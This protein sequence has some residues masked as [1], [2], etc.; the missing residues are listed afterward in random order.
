MF[1]LPPNA[2]PYPQGAGEP[3]ADDSPGP[4][5]EP[6]ALEIARAE[7]PYFPDI[8]EKVSSALVAKGE[9]RV[10]ASLPDNA[11]RVGCSTAVQEVQ[12]DPKVRAAYLGEAPK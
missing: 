2:S 8:G 9:D 7:K 3:E 11:N 12:A 6:S 1:A 10:V 4:R 5:A